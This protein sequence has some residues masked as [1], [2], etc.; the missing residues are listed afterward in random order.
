MLAD[1]HNLPAKHDVLP[2]PQRKLWRMPKR[3]RVNLLLMSFISKNSP[4]THVFYGLNSILTELQLFF[5]H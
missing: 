5:Q 2:R 3:N 1:L 4:K